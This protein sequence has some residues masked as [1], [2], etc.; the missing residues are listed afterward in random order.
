MTG[1]IK[2]RSEG[3]WTLIISLGKDPLTGRRRQKWYTVRGNK[4]AAEAEL[5]RLL[6]ELNTGSYVELCWFSVKMRRESRRRG[7]IPP[8][9]RGF[10]RHEDL[11][12]RCGGAGRRRL[13]AARTVHRLDESTKLSLGMVAS[14]QSPLPFHLAESLSA[15]RLDRLRKKLTRPAGPGRSLRAAAWPVRVCDPEPCGFPHAG[16][17]ASP[18]V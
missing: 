16:L 5:T 8:F 1:S 3:S 4:K 10:S 12:N 7:R 17:R 13:Y 11:S 6:H 15:T 9:G 14:P 2:K 18:T